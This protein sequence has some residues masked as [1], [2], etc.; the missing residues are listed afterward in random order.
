MKKLL[1]LF[2]CYPQA[3]RQV[4]KTEKVAATFSSDLIL[5]KPGFQ[6]VSIVRDIRKLYF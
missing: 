6:A 1:P 4:G 2:Q 3:G 5:R